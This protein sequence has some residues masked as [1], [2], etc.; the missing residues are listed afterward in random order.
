MKNRPYLETLSWIAAIF[1]TFWAIWVYFSPPTANDH[2]LSEPYL[3]K[4]SKVDT[5][6]PLDLLRKLASSRRSLR[7]AEEVLGVPLEESKYHRVY[8][9]Y[10]YRITILGI[11]DDK[12]YD[13][14]TIGPI[15][16]PNN[17]PPLNLSGPWDET[18]ETFRNLTLE[19]FSGCPVSDWN[20]DANSE[21]M[22][23]FEV[24]CG[25]SQAQAKLYVRAG[26]SYACH[27]YDKASTYITPEVL[28]KEYEIFEEQQHN[29]VALTAEQLYEFYSKHPERSPTIS[30]TR[31]NYLT[32]SPRQRMEP[33]GAG[34][35]E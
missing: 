14:V 21:C 18:L 26:V 22:N 16:A 27:Y 30:R 32:I 5:D 20:Y 34:G 25:G 28:R 1:G 4:K 8:E 19:H 10:G 12:S 9:K 2:P 7:Y 23:V 35:W 6:P 15:I 24:E 3:N 13:T 31:I 29:R 33:A 11:V 17:L